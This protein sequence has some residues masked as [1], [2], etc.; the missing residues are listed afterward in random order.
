MTAQATGFGIH[1]LVVDVLVNDARLH[2]WLHGQNYRYAVKKYAV[3]GMMNNKWARGYLAKPIDH[4][5]RLMG[6]KTVT[7]VF[8]NVNVGEEFKITRD[9][10]TAPGAFMMLHPKWEAIEKDLET[11]REWEGRR[12]VGSFRVVW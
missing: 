12:K 3:E 8:P 10:A 4:D 7:A 9:L 11:I 6:C 1:E 2:K 5:G